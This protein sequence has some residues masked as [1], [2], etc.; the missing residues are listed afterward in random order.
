[1]RLSKFDNAGARRIENDRRFSV[2]KQDTQFSSIITILAD[3]QT[4][5]LLQ[6]QRYLVREPLEPCFTAPSL[7]VLQSR[8]NCQVPP[9][10]LVRRK[11]AVLVT[12]LFK[13]LGFMVFSCSSCVTTNP[14]PLAF[15]NQMSQLAKTMLVLSG[16]L[17]SKEVV[18]RKS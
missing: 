13:V 9:Q 10:S 12:L 2:N 1:M 16:I 15:V 11:K 14:S 8:E 18:L 7:A 6:H 4:V 17:V 3:F 5:Q